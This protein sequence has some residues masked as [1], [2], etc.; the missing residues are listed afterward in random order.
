MPVLTS[1]ATTARVIC[2]RE[3]GGKAV[4][5][6]IRPHGLDL[7]VRFLRVP[8]D[9]FW[10]GAESRHLLAPARCECASIGSPPLESRRSRFIGGPGT[11]GLRRSAISVLVRPRPRESCGCSAQALEGGGGGVVDRGRGAFPPQVRLRIGSNVPSGSESVPL[12]C[13]Q[14]NRL[15]SADQRAIERV[16]EERYSDSL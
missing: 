12:L 1:R 11:Q 6:P 9:F 4:V 15:P 8:L 10:G 2:L 3:V 16:A 5:W 7:G 14:T 13:G